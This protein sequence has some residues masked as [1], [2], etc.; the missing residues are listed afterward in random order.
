MARLG[1]MHDV[2]AGQVERGD[3]P[4]IVILT[5]RRGEVLV[6]AIGTK[7]VGASDPRTMEVKLP[8]TRPR[9]RALL[10]RVRRCCLGSVPD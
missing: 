9:S 2:M 10:R 3:A 8:A 5:G 4:G 6:D 7:A 1:R